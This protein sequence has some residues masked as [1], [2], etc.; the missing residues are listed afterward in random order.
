MPINALDLTILLIKFGLS[1]GGF[2]ITG[3][4]FLKIKRAREAG[5]EVVPFLGFSLSFLFF[6]ITHIIYLYYDFYMWDSGTQS[7]LLFKAANILGSCG[8]TALVFFSE[9]ILQKTKFVLTGAY[10]VSAIIGIFFLSTIEQSRLFLTIINLSS[11][12]IIFSGFL[13]SMI[14]KT[15]GEIRRKMGMA[16][17]CYFGFMFAYLLGSETFYSLFNLAREP[18]Q[19]ISYIGQSVALVIW[20]GIFL[21]FE[22]FTEFGWKDKMKELVIIAPNGGTLFHHKF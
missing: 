2:I 3:M 9:K 13:Y 12:P 6:G 5:T 22:T 18:A 7:F 16:F 19:I 4:F 10:I 14:V 17:L 20:G 1:L 21:G 11:T 8:I 15:K